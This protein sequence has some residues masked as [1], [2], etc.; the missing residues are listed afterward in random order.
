MLLASFP[1]SRAQEPGNEARML[2]VLFLLFLLRTGNEAKVCSLGS[3][4]IA[5]FPGSP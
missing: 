1:G 5:S 3:I 2:L 4:T